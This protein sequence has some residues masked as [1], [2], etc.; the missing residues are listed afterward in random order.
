M[1]GQHFVYIA[2]CAD[3]SLYAGYTT[4][5]ER[6]IATHNA[7]KGAKYTRSRL[8]VRL[9]HT[10]GYATKPLAMKRE[11]EIK[12]MTRGEKLRLI[13]ACAGR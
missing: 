9:V 13:R 11:A 2:E 1:D 4:D 8:P 3:G 6:R 7:G 12:R 10:E 5:P